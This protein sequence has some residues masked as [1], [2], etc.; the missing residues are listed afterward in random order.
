MMKKKTSVIAASVA[1]IAVCTSIIAGSTFALFTSESSVDV[2]VKSAKVNVTA[3][4]VGDVVTN[5]DEALSGANNQFTAAVAG[6]VL[7]LNNMAPG[8][9]VEFKIEVKN[10]STISVLYNT[11]LSGENSELFDA[12]DI[13]V[14][15]EAKYR[16][17]YSTL[18]A[19]TDSENGEV[20]ETVNVKI[21]LPVDYDSVF[22]GEGD[23]V[24]GVTTKLTFKVNAIQG[25][26]KYIGYAPSS[27]ALNGNSVLIKDVFDHNAPIEVSG[28]GTLVLDNV[29]V[30]PTE[31]GASA[32]VIAEGANVKLE[33]K[34][35]C[36][37]KG[38]KNGDGITVPETASLD[39]SGDKLT[40]VG[41]NGYEYFDAAHH[42]EGCDDS[43]AGTAGGGIFIAGS[44]NIHDVKSLTAEGYGKGFTK[45]V[46]IGGTTDNL[47]ISDTVIEYA[48]G[49]MAGDKPFYDSDYAKKGESEG[50][51]AIGTLD[52]GKVTLT[53]VTVKEA[54]GGVKSA[55]IGGACHKSVNIQITNCTLTNII[56]GHSAAAIG[57]GRTDNKADYL[58]SVTIQDSDITAQGG[59]YGAG[60]GS[61]YDTYC[62]GK[63]T[64]EIYIKGNSAIAAVGGVRAAGI[65]TGYHIGHLKG[66]IEGTVD[67]AGT[68]ANE[69]NW[70][71]NTYTTAQDIGYGVV[72]PG[73][74][75]KDE[76]DNITFKVGGQVIDAPYIG[77]K[78]N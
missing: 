43:Y 50:C 6:N 7:T 48:R 56:G 5:Y 14:N 26:A 42:S 28:E 63:T 12:L 23:A 19:A 69:D 33:I 67:T 9:S 45:S 2:V 70:Y 66:Y 4:V 29:N 38:A 35:E 51:P 18:A 58:I 27:V 55:A 71:K 13:K 77:E 22:T 36:T 15:G 39:L 61:G 30:N 11:E 65:G 47:V 25:N 57:G 24:Q 1:A 60:I 53:N 68:K 76:K 3:K 44:A 21:S 20:V 16:T 46:G 52:G 62:S 34:G 49:G 32:L 73:R 41:N 17:M 10:Y 72:D 54:H 64:T 75:Y 74:E 40:A 8:D 37:L 31:V 78:L 59:Y